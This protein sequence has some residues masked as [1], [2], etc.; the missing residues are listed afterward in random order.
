MADIGCA[1]ILVTDTICGPMKR[2]PLEGELLAIDQMPSK[3]R[4]RGQR[5]D[6]PGQTRIRRRRLRMCRRRCVGGVLLQSLAAAA[7][8]A[9]RSGISIRTR[10]QDVILLVEGED[11]RY[12][13][14][15]GAT[16]PSRSG[17]SN[18]TGSTA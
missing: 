7:W 5:G 12:I 13:H 6:R 2:L 11:R 18:A 4:L 3:A 15:F 10:Q 17:N 14:V 1:G 8:A 9:N 16:P